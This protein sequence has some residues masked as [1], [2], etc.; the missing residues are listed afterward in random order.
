MTITTTYTL[1]CSGIAT[2]S[3]TKFNPTLYIT[4]KGLPTVTAVVFLDGLDAAV[5]DTSK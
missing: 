2:E 3:P 4:V 5:P 1:H